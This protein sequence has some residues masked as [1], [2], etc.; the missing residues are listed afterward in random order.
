VYIY[1]HWESVHL[2][3]LG[4]CTFT[5]INSESAIKI[6]RKIITLCGNPFWIRRTVSY[7]CFPKAFF[8]LHNLTSIDDIFFDIMN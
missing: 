7:K 6:S 8:A 3:K 1:I 4:E 2:Y 5:K